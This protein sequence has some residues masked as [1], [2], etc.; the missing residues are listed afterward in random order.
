MIK[1]GK[2]GFIIKK[3]Q[4]FEKIIKN[5]YKNKSIKKITQNAKNDILNIYNTDKM[6]TK[7]YMLYG[8]KKDNDKIKI[9]QYTERWG[10]GGIESFIMNL[11]RNLDL[12]KFKMDILTSQNES[13]IYD[14]EL[15]KYNGIKYTTLDK[16]YKSPIKRVLI[17]LRVFRKKIKMLDYDIIHLN[18]GNGVS[19]IYAY[20]A[21]KEGIKRIIV[22]SHNTGIQNN[23]RTLKILGHKIC[24]RLFCKYATDYFACSDKAA[25]WLFTKKYQKNVI[26]IKNGIDVDRFKFILSER[27]NLRR[28]LNLENK[29]VIGN[30]GRFTE[31]KNHEFLI[32]IFYDIH[33]QRL[34]TVLLLV[35]EGELEEKI[36]NKVK[37]LKLEKDVIFFGTT[38]KVSS[39]LS[40][41]DIFVLPSLYEGN[42]VVGIEAQASGLPCFFSNNITK[43]AK[44]TSNAYYVSLKEPVEI[45]RKKILCCNTTLTNRPEQVKVVKNAGF[46]IKDVTKEI[47]NIYLMEC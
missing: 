15:E 32:D 40:I 26:I 42:P 19:L 17:N 33:S 4:D 38:N 46:D 36:K 28:K 7:Y 24:K 6:I 12:R 30:I 27:E 23:S 2:N 41:M 5:I 43:Q 21:K 31:Q 39:I 35:G 18:V 8:I 20:L 47:E 37:E 29:L 11:Y 1:N 13:T 16:I 10:T 14:K 9:L 34:D 25:Q 3:S 45:W 44:I 22:H